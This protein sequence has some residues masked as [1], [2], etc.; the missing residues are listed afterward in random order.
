[1]CFLPSLE[2]VLI[3]L[4]DTDNDDDGYEGGANEGSPVTDEKEY[5]DFS[6]VGFHLLSKLCSDIEAAPATVNAE[7]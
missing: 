2:K 5:D 4:L 1:M 7:T 6:S 3:T